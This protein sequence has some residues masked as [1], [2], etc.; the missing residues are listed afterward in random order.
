MKESKKLKMN[1]KAITKKI[2]K[3]GLLIT[4]FLLLFSTVA[5][6]GPQG[7]L[8]GG[9]DDKIM[10]IVKTIASYAWKFGLIMIFYGALQVGIAFK[11]DEPDKK[12]KGIKWCIA[13]SIVTAVAMGFDKFVTF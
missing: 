13:G 4:L 8:T 1:V 6:A 3:S 7:G 12:A 10:L 9:E 2:L 11:D 5:F